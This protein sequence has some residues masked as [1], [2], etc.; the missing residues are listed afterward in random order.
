[1][2]RAPRP[3]MLR[4]PPSQERRRW[5][6][7]YR[8]V[9]RVSPPARGCR[10]HG[11]TPPGHRHAGIVSDRRFALVPYCLLFLPFFCGLGTLRAAPAGPL[12]VAGP[13]G[14]P[15]ALAKTRSAAQYQ[16]WKRLRPIPGFGVLLRGRWPLGARERPR[17]P[18]ADPPY[19]RPSPQS[20]GPPARRAA[21]SSR[22]QDAHSGGR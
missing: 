4:R 7:G 18:A 8:P 3:C 20:A 19:P 17:T 13:V 22:L 2:R 14:R 12:C 16:G 1:M 15:R 21:C 6:S 5:G 10:N 11:S 9:S